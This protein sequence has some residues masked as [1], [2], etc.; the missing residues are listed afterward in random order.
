MNTKN[1]NGGLITRHDF[2]PT[3]K[4]SKWNGNPEDG[5]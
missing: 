4:I 2:F 5:S 1:T 3:A